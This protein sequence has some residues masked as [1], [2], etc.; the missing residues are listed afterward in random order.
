MVISKIH[1]MFPNPVQKDPGH[2]NIIITVT[3]PEVFRGSL[4]TPPRF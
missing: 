2:L 1:E 4:E 3:D